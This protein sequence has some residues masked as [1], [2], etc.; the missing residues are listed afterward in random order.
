MPLYSLVAWPPRELAAWVRRV[1]AERGLASFGPP[2]L[3]VRTPFEFAGDEGELLRAADATRR[4]LRAF[5]ARFRGWRRFPHTLF[6]ELHPDPA[7]LAAHGR[8]LAHLPAPA[9]EHDGDGFLPHLTLALGVCPWASDAAWAA[10]RDL[11]PPVL[12]WTVD[13]LALT[14]EERGDV[15]ELARYPLAP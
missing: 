1:Q 11:V 4:G 14:R 12:A 2:H 13:A 7:L 9:T 15:V 8:A 5:E 10:V 3:S 6:L